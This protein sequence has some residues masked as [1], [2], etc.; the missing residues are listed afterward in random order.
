MKKMTPF[1]AAMLGLMLILGACGGKSAATQ[2]NA[3]QTENTVGTIRVGGTTTGPPFSFLNEKNENIGLMFDIAKKVVEGIGGKAEI[4]GMTFTSLIPAIESDKID[5]ISAGMFMTDE[6]KQVID[7]SDPIFSY[8]EAIVIKKNDDSIKSFDDL[9][10]KKVGSSAGGLYTEK[11][12]AYPEIEVLEYKSTA[13]MIQEIDNGRIDA[14][15]QDAPI[16]IH[17]IKENP[18]MNIKLL[19]GY[20][21]QWVNDIGLGLPKDSKIKDQVNA[22]IKRLKESGEIDAILSEWGL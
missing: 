13:D 6:R 4:E 10:G 17:L 21:S 22:E 1:L 9:K 3:G 5:M 14:F 19:E 18:D 12:K 16:V 8:G 11:L 7:F 15:F 2:G 20:E